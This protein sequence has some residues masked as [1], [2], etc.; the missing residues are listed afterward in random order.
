[1]RVFFPIEKK[2][3]D[4]NGIVLLFYFS[5]EN[6]KSAKKMLSSKTHGLQYS[7]NYLSSYALQEENLAYIQ[8]IQTIGSEDSILPQG[9][10]FSLKRVLGGLEMEKDRVSSAFCYL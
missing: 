2:R 4:N 3:D 10:A 1:M 6:A 9:I 7:K 8:N 5:A